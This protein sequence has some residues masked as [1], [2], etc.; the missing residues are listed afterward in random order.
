[1]RS[2]FVVLVGAGLSTASGIPDYRSD[3]G[4]WK[5]FDPEEFHIDRFLADPVRFW[6][7]R[8]DLTRKMRLLDAEPNA[9]HIALAQAATRGDVEAIVTQNVDGL[10]QRA[11][12]PSERLMEVHG[13]AANCVCM[14]CGD[15]IPTRDV[16]V[17]HEAGTAP[18]CPCGGYLKPDVVLFGEA[19]EKID[20]AI[21]AVERAET[22]VTVGTSLQVW[23][24]AGLAQLALRQGAGLII[25]N[26]DPTPFDTLAD[27]VRRGDV[28]EELR[29][30]FTG[31][32]G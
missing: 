17:R 15:L 1:V 30:L 4:M 7:R 19:V 10:H 16:I 23:P 13:I 29:F 5:M 12:T 2:P 28:V 27:E 31:E 9:G 14:S 18:C 24:V 6:E 22:L 21:A 25:L 11:G 8:V 20:D 32:A 3:A 26:R